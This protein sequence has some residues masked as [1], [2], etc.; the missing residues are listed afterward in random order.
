M[1]M[2]GAGNSARAEGELRRGFVDAEI[3]RIE[4]VLRTNLAIPSTATG[5]KPKP[6]RSSRPSASLTRQSADQCPCRLKSIGIESRSEA[7]RTARHSDYM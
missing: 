6:G 4:A 7:R 1:T 2:L 3:T 5:Q